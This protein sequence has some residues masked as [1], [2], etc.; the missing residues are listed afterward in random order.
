MSMIHP[1]SHRL[2]CCIAA[3]VLVALLIM[4]GAASASA[5]LYGQ[6][7]LWRVEANG[8]PTSYVFGTM[9][10]SDERIL[11]LPEP[12]LQA[13]DASQRCLFELI[14]PQDGFTLTITEMQLPEG[15]SLRDIVGD[16]VYNKVVVAAGRYGIPTALI[17][18]M[19]PGALMLA[20]RSPP[21]EWQ[22]RLD[23]WAFLDLALQNEARAVGKEI[24]A[25][26]T[27]EEQLA[28]SE[29]EKGINIALLL[30]GM[31]ENSFRMEQDMETLVQYYLRRDMDAFFS[32]EEGHIAL[33]PQGEREAYA[34]F[35]VRLLDRRNKTMVE[36]MLPH[37][38]AAKS[39][40]AVGAAHLSGAKGILHLLEQQ[41][42]TVSRVY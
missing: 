21:S 14:V 1:C 39:F 29:D 4:P 36:R 31:I 24:Y 34:R 9:H 10:M 27:I 32:R 8:Y 3:T 19:H 7:L 25:L 26:E 12:V 11:Q 42:F 28:I 6:G 15:I 16:D 5:R 13:F 37:L 23:G 17:G 18:R 35:V 41:G 33:Q 22:R 30:N 40:V 38:Q 2:R 20:F